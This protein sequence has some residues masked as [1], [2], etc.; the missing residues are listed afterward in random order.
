VVV[1]KGAETFDVLV[2]DPSWVE[3]GSIDGDLAYG[4]AGCLTELE[5]GPGR[6]ARAASRLGQADAARHELPGEAGGG[7]TAEAVEAADLIN[8]LIPRISVANAR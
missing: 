6:G 8:L 2:A 1:P 7:A 3:L 5:P 4:R